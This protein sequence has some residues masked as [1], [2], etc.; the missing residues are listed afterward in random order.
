MIR[1]IAAIVDITEWCIGL[2]FMRSDINSSGFRRINFESCNNF[3]FV[4][5]MPVKLGTTS[6]HKCIKIM[7]VLSRRPE[8]VYKKRSL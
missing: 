1:K 7:K 5:S 2:N 4:G 8:I 6:F 3:Y